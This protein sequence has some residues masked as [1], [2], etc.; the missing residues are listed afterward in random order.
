M[1]SCHLKEKQM[2]A[3]RGAGSHQ[4]EK[5]SCRYSVTAKYVKHV[6]SYRVVSSFVVSCVAPLR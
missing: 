3:Q 2:A 4:T 5:T 6:L 1:Q